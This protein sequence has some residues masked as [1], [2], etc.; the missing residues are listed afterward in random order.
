MREFLN[1]YKSQ[2]NANGQLKELSSNNNDHKQL[3]EENFTHIRHP[4]P[5]LTHS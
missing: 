1:F 5:A 3:G 4:V 2:S